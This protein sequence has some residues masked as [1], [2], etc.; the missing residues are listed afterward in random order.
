MLVSFVAAGC[1]SG[2]PPAT[3]TV[4]LITSTLPATQVPTGTAVPHP[5]LQPTSAP[6]QGIT[7]SRLNVRGGPSSASPPLG[8]IDPFTTVLI[9][10]RDQSGNWYQIQFPQG[11]QG[12]G[13]VTAQYVTVQNPAAIPVVT[14][15]AGAAPSGV[16]MQQV[17]VRSGPGTDANSV[18][19]LN[20]RDVVALTGKDQTGLWLQIQYQAGPDG[21][22]W[23]AAG[24][25]QANG[26][27]QLP[28][29]GQTGQLIGTETPTA[30]PPTA[31][32]T[33]GIAV[34]DNDSAQ[35]PAADV[36]FSPA[37][38]G[39][40]I[41]SSSLS[42]PAGDAEDWIRFTPYESRLRI[43]LAC[44]GNGDLRLALTTK[45]LPVI[46]QQLP[47]CGATTML[48]LVA[49][50]PYLLQLTL[51]AVTGQQQYL[52]YTLTVVNLP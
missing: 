44:L 12:F 23:V 5:T 11:N 6:I 49:M 42:T 39:S 48:T 29:V 17:N 30:V 36:T 14:S 50:Q 47:G 37:G 32:P 41:Y 2:A 31:L 33:P 46:N 35:A 4:Y 52:Q 9:Q 26:F 16:I 1:I 25:V 19:A 40:L 43:G 21:K 10:A 34:Q 38:A 28:I 51:G 13:W 3:A 22:G 45:S 24:Y 27:D 7:T 15:A 8:M 20:A 18:G